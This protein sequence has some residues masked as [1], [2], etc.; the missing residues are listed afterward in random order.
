MSPSSPTTRSATRAPHPL[1]HTA[2]RDPLRGT[3]ARKTRNARAAQHRAPPGVKAAQATGKRTPVPSPHPRR[4]CTLRAMSREDLRRANMREDGSLSD[5]IPR[6]E[7]GTPARYWIDR[8]LGAILRGLAAGRPQRVL[9]LGCQ[10]G[11]YLAMLS[12]AGIV[13]DYVGIDVAP[14]AHWPA[15]EAAAT[16]G[17]RGEFRVHDA[18]SVDTLQP[19]GFDLVLSIATFEHF[20]DD[21]RV[22][23]GVASQLV[24]G[25]HFVLIVP[26][27]YSLL[28][29]GPHGYRRYE[30]DALVSR[31]RGHG[32]EI[33]RADDVGGLTSFLWHAWLFGSSQALALSGKA[34]LGFMAGLSRARAKRLFPGLEQTLNNAMFLHQRWPAGRTAHRLLNRVTARLDETLTALPAVYMLIARRPVAQ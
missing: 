33:A 29:Y 28:L 15:A 4:W 16:A 19:A 7:L 21:E 3:G 17:L 8:H 13:G 6:G 27:E 14:S 9:D 24:P 11:A 2:D 22:L 20:R 25:G 5:R 12:N 32:L 31:L 23:A 30:K 10:D 1:V 26:S 18:H 34:A